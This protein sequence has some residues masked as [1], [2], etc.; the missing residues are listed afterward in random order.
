MVRAIATRRGA[1]TPARRCRLLRALQAPAQQQ[2]A[3]VLWLPLPHWQKK[4]TVLAFTTICWMAPMR[5]RSEQT[6]QKA[7]TV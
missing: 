6:K 7:S 4:Q 1:S 5:A 3:Q 2:P